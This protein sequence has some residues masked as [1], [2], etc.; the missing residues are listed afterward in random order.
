[1]ISIEYDFKNGK[2]QR[3]A[4]GNST[5]SVADA[6]QVSFTSRHAGA[7]RRSDQ[8]PPSQQEAKPPLLALNKTNYHLMHKKNKQQR[9]IAAQQRAHSGAP[10]AR[11]SCVVKSSPVNTARGADH[12]TRDAALGSQILVA[13]PQ[14]ALNS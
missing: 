3:A 9:K 7:D 14:A 2:N 1:M 11:L 8:S 5:V 12:A 10:S 4:G 6:A 13:S